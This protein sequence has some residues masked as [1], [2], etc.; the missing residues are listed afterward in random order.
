MHQRRW[1]AACVRKMSRIREINV[2][3][4]GSFNDK[5]LKNCTS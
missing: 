2:Y 3:I 1:L 5:A 4:V